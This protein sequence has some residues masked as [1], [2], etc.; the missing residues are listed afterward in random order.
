MR[1][2]N[3]FFFGTNLKMNQTPAETRA[4]LAAIAPAA[5]QSADAQ[6]WVMPPYTSLAAAAPACEE[7][8]IW[9]G[10]QNMHTE[11]SGAYTGEISARMLAA[12]G[13][14]MVMLGHAERRG[15]FGETD[16][17]L[18]QKVPLAG[19]HGLRVMLCV[20]ESGADK[21]AGTGAA[22]VERQLEMALAQIAP[23][24][25]PVAAPR[26]LVLY[27]P[28]WSIGAGGE[29]ADPDYAGEVMSAIGSWLAGRFPE[30]PVPVL[31]GG[32]VDI[33]NVARYAALPGCDGV[34]VGR[35]ALRAES[36]VE[37]M[38]VAMSSWRSAAARG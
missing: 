33:H 4:Y 9:L 36:F 12:S 32:S 7:A 38:A 26:L 8:G 5:R 10:A 27:E 22:K 29:P 14:S 3:T 30:Q 19:R 11:E 20:G 17:A 21:R 16:Q 31:Y 37:I 15:S 34:G 24:G 23:A 2:T 18:G 28:V 6:L 1:K 35:A 13:C 25:S